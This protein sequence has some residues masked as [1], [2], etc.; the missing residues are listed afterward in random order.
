MYMT[1]IFFIF[2]SFIFS[3]ESY[4]SSLNSCEQKNYWYLQKIYSKI[5]DFYSTVKYLERKVKERNVV[6]E[7]VFVLL[8]NILIIGLTTQ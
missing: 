5:I 4:I 7:I 2:F 6:G 8:I 1:E 3:S